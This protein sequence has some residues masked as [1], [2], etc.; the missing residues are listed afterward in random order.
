MIAETPLSGQE[1]DIPEACFETNRSTRT[2]YIIFVIILSLPILFAIIFLGFMLRALA[3]NLG[4]PIPVL[5]AVYVL[6]CAL[7]IHRVWKIICH[8]LCFCIIFYPQRLQAGRGLVRCTFPYEDIDI[9]S[10]NVINKDSSISIICGHAKARVFLVITQSIECF[11]LLSQ[12]CNNAVI[13]DATGSVHLPQNPNNPVKTISS[14][15]RHFTEKISTN[16]IYACFW[17]G[18]AIWFTI[19][20][21]ANWRM[22]IIQLNIF[23]LHRLIITIV[24]GYAGTVVCVWRIY[25]SWKT[26]IYIR[27]KQTNIN[28]LNEFL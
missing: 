4:L 7:C 10:M 25:K 24:C 13:I 19:E 18:I 6:F 15:T 14:L 3:N 9:I 8:K 1:D 2:A 26:F 16:F 21:L 12:H 5:I 11:R 27:D 17:G 22:G 28:N 20:C 23:D